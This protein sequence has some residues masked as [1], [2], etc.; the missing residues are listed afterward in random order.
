MCK[1]SVIMGIYNC[2]NTL[3]ESIDSILTQT[4]K[5]WELIMCDDGSKDNTYKIAKS[6]AEK[7]K[8]IVVFRNEKNQGLAY[9]LNKCIEKSSGKYIARMDGDDISLPERLERQVEYL[10]N[11]Q[12]VDI[13]GTNVYYFDEQGVW[14]KSNAKQQLDKI[15][16]A[17]GKIFAHPS[18]MM[19]KSC[20]EVVGGY[21]SNKLTRRAEDYDLWC[22]MY[23]KG[24]NGE[25]LKDYLF[26]YRLDSNAYKKRKYK[27]RV[28]EFRLKRYW[29]KRFK[30]NFRYS[31]F[32]IKPLIVGLIP[33]SIMLKLHKKRYG[34]K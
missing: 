20:L 1:V 30:L 29:H 28:E 27:H 8:Q 10:E 15:D 7:Y 23:E 5:D 19:K 11:N 4:Y 18:V 13:L 2:E 21:I 14:G 25:N 16:I 32:Y 3:A 9:S 34:V 31:K 33:C 12:Q 26:K 17:C 22:R 6:Y 24:F